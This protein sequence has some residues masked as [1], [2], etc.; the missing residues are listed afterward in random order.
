MLTLH[1][2]D[3]LEG[4]CGNHLYPGGPEVKRAQGGYGLSQQNPGLADG[5][6]LYVPLMC[7]PPASSA[8]LVLGLMTQKS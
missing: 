5:Q 4:V 8:C 1:P 2:T 6:P 7:S 3:T